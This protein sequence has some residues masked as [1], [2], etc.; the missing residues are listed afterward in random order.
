MEGSWSQRA[1]TNRLAVY[2]VEFE[3]ECFEEEERET[4][5]G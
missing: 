3:R 5:W 2:P 1:E 4:E